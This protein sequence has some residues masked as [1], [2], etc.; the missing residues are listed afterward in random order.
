M[1]HQ[2]KKCFNEQIPEHVS[3]YELH[4]YTWFINCTNTLRDFNQPVP[5]HIMNR[6]RR[7]EEMNYIHWRVEDTTVCKVPIWLIGTA[8]CNQQG[9]WIWCVTY[10]FGTVGFSADLSQ[11]WSL[12]SVPWKMTEVWQL[13]TNLLMWT[14]PLR[15]L[16]RSIIDL[17]L[18]IRSASVLGFFPSGECSHWYRLWRHP[19]N[20]R[21]LK[22]VV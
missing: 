11:S 16:W 7:Q 1:C 5:H 8:P 12:R 20:A 14:A 22:H 9:V 21:I 17:C 4:V 10:H 6:H 19:D 18:R 3:Y 15:R 2:K 13:L